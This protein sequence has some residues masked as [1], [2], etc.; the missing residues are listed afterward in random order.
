MANSC[1]GACEVFA[2]RGGGVL[3]YLAQE[4]RGIGLGNKLR[5]YALQQQG[6]D[7]VD[8]DC[9]LGFGADERDYTAAVQMLRQ[10][11]LQRI[12]LLTNNPEK[13]R[14]VEQGGIEVTD[15]QP[16][17]GTLNR[18]NLR[19]VTAKVNRAGHWLGEMLS[20]A[21]AGK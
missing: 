20:G 4:G 2:A 21:V 3:L 13:V 1:A 16:L 14:A 5:A 18:H 19:Y 15:R 6:L 9:T 8:A 17:Y 11:R 7:T 12:Q 10:L